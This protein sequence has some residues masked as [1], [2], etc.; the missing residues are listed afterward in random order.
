MKD[1]ILPGIFFSIFLAVT[2]KE[3]LTETPQNDKVIPETKLNMRHTNVPTITIQY[4]H[5]CGYQKA[6]QEYAQI[7]KEKYP[8]IDVHGEYYE[9]NGLYTLL[10]RF[11]NFSRMVL[12]IL[13]ILQKNVFLMLGW[14]TPNWWMWCLNNKIYACLT[15]FFFS[16]MFE[17]MLISSGAFEI[18]MDGVPLWSKIDSGRVPQPKELFRIIDSQM[19]FEHTINF[20]PSYAT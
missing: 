12:I 5:S 2:I 17:N 20:E 3:L 19:N 7:L 16:N 13:I 10:A 9:S 15:I 6:F 11:L 1:K 18:S 4:C 8:N 14:Q